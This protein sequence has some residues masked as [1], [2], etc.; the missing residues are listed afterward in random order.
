MF[1]SH[2]KDLYAMSSM[3]GYCI[4]ILIERIQN[5]ARYFQLQCSAPN[6]YIPFELN[7]ISCFWVVDVPNDI[8][9]LSVLPF[10]KCCFLYIAKN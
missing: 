5:P 8:Y 3:S 7:G 4:L 10:R 6:D 1:D 2:L 9:A